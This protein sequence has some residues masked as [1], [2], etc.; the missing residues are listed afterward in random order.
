MWVGAGQRGETRAR[1]VALLRDAGDDPV[2]QD[3]DE[4]CLE[5]A[6]RIMTVLG[7]PERCRE[8]AC[9]RGRRCAGKDLLL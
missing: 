6:R 9:R 1:A 4:F 5:L 2:P 3:I 8:R 7:L